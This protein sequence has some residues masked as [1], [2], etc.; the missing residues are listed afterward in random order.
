MREFITAVYSQTVEHGMDK[1]DDMNIPNAPTTATPVQDIQ[2]GI[3][4]ETPDDGNTRQY[5]LALAGTAVILIVLII[6]VIVRKKKDVILQQ[7]SSFRSVP[8]K[9]VNNT[10]E[11]SC[12]YTNNIRTEEV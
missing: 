1:S 2:V 6:L 11:V 5:H 7:L 9:I 3:P 12:Q 8:C 10:K 4:P